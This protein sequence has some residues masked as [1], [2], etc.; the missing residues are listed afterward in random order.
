MCNVLLIRLQNHLNVI[1]VNMKAYVW[2]YEAIIIIIAQ[3]FM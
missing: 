1:H 3:S 2:L